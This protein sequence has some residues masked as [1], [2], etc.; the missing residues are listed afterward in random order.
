MNREF[1]TQLNVIVGEYWRQRDGVARQKRTSASGNGFAPSSP[2]VA[3]AILKQSLSSIS[4]EVVDRFF[5]FCE[6]EAKEQFKDIQ[7]GVRPPD[8]AFDPFLKDNENGLLSALGSV[9]GN[10]KKM[11]AKN[12]S[13]AVGIAQNA[14]I[15]A[16]ESRIQT[17]VTN[18]FERGRQQ[19]AREVL[20]LKCSRKPSGI[21]QT[22][23]EANG[24]SVTADGRPSTVPIESPPRPTPE[25]DGESGNVPSSK[26][27]F[28]FCPDG[29]GYFLRGFGEEGHIAAKGAIGLHDIFRLVQSVG[30]P[31]PM[32]ELDAGTG[33][34]RRSGDSQSK[35]PIANSQTRNDITAKR[36]GLM[37]DIERAD[38][39]LERAELQAELEKLET[40]AAKLFGLN[41]EPRDVNNPNNKLRPKI[42]GRI[43]D[44]CAKL[45]NCE[46]KPFPLIAEHFE[47]TIGAEGACFKY[48][49]GI[50][51]LLWRTEPTSKPQTY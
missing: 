40:E 22:G 42:H 6:N 37:A 15:D 27:Q 25:A 18:K 49:P 38:T 14:R 45:K 17:E 35:Q 50:P 28:V 19:F 10:L 13:Q 3:D 39:V 12:P 24:Q 30:S 33:T 2:C 46:P 41:G 16:E 44:V 1:I 47:L 11:A 5:Q 51:N 7:H 21:P 36:R 34:K 23:I 20:R 43:R 26:S 31:V 4:S 48:S 9:I 32:L 8:Q 29:N